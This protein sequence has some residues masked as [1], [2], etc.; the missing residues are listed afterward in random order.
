MCVAVAGGECGGGRGV[1]Y[2]DEDG[3]DGE[4]AEGGTTLDARAM[5]SPRSDGSSMYRMDQQRHSGLA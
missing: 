2:G 1:T 4:D 3:E 5:M